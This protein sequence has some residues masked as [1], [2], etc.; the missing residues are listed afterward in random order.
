MRRYGT[1]K[2]SWGQ[3]NKVVTDSMGNV[4]VAGYVDTGVT[5]YAG[6]Q[7]LQCGRAAVDQSLR[8]P[9]ERS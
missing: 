2:N 6:G 5:G 9:G 3:F 8:R 7:I 4:I 1:I